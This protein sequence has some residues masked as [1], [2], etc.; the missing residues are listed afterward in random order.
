[1]GSAFPA[2]YTGTCEALGCGEKIEEGDLVLYIDDVLVHKRCEITE[3]SKSSLRE[4]LCREC[5]TIHSPGQK[6]CE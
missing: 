5:F 4:K 6:V 1:M 3:F 2:K